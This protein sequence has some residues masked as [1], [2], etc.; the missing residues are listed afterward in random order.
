MGRVVSTFL[1]IDGQYHMARYGQDATHS[2]EENYCC[3]IIDGL[4]FSILG[5]ETSRNSDTNVE[6]EV[7][8]MCASVNSGPSRWGDRANQ[9]KLGKMATA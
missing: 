1:S 9:A 4:I 3:L 7:V 6:I 5:N 2:K 8:E